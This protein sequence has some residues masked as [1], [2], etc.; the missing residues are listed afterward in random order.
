MNLSLRLQTILNH[1]QPV[2]VLADIGCDHG[3]LLL[4]ALKSTKCEFGIGTDVRAMPLKRAQETLKKAGYQ[5]QTVFYQTDGMK[6]IPEE[7]Q[8]W[9][10][11]GM[12]AELMV[13]IINDS[14]N[15]AQQT[16]Q[17]VMCPHHQPE[18]L[19]L[20]MA[21]LGFEVIKEDL[22]FD[23]H[24]YWV[25]SYQYHGQ[26]ITLSLYEQYFGQLKKAQ[27]LSY[28]TKLYQQNFKHQQRNPKSKQLIE[29]ITKE[30]SVDPLQVLAADD[31][32]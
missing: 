9:V 12:G 21:S 2:P 7:A 6:N 31:Q 28:A 15:K 17:I 27:L 20:K 32:D 5:Q 8:C 18:I 1:I 3:K 4:A 22:I 29:L 25:I 26:T 19:R 11:A 30:F 24:F 23:D 10:L 16:T 13:K 14:I